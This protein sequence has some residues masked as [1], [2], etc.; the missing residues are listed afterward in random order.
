MLLRDR[1]KPK[2]DPETREILTG[3]Y[4]DDVDALADVLARTPPWA[5]EI[6]ASARRSAAEGAT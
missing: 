1:A 2:M 3:F 5:N 6:Y 4:R